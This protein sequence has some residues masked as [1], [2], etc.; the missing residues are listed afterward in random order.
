MPRITQFMTHWNNLREAADN[1]RQLFYADGSLVDADV[2]SDLWKYVSSGHRGGCWTWL[3]AYFQSSQ[4]IVASSANRPLEMLTD[5]KVIRTGN[6]RD[7]VGT[8]TPLDSYLH[9]NAY[10]D[11]SFNAQGLPI[12]TAKSIEQQYKQG[13]NIYFWQPVDGRV[14]RFGANS[15]GSVLNCDRDPSNRVSQLGV[16]ACAEGTDALKNIV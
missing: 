2:I 1:K 14:A 16:F 13:K 5:L 10:V 11:L 7:F 6:N 12:P 4:N 3:N 15:A 8:S 9:E